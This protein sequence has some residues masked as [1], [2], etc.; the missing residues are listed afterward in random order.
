[1]NKCELHTLINFP[2]LPNLEQLELNQNN[3]KEVEL[4]NFE[5]CQNLKMICLKKN[6]FQS[7]EGLKPLNELPNLFDVHISDHLLTNNESK[8]RL[9]EIIENL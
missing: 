1:M 6:N 4:S 7:I 3:L 9:F 8:E 2:E 5:K